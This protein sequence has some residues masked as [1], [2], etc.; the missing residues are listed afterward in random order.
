MEQLT[1]DDQFI[2]D[3][4]NRMKRHPYLKKKLKEM[5]DD[6]LSEDEALNI[7]IQVWREKIGA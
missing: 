6:G 3:M 7:M 1:I 5:T 4:K 2:E